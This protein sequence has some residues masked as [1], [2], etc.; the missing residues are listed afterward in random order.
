M[1][2]NG[3]GHNVKPLVAVTGK[4]T[5]LRALTFL[6]IGQA[7]IIVCAALFGGVS[8]QTAIFIGI[9]INGLIAAAALAIR[10]NAAFAVGDGSP[11]D[12]E[13]EQMARHAA[14]LDAFP[15]PILLL[16]GENRVELANSAT[17]EMFGELE[18]GAP[19]TSVVRAPSALEVLR[20]ARHS[21][22]PQEEEFTISA[23]SAMTALFYAAP[24]QITERAEKGEMI[25]M[26]RDRT[27]Q[28]MLERMRTDFLAN[29]GHE[30]RTPLA[31]LLGFIET[32]Q[33]HARDDAEA[34]AKFLKIM[35]SQTE[36]MLR[37]VQDL[38]SLS[39]LELNER[40]VP[41]ETVDL[42]EMAQ[43]TRDM[44]APVVERGNG[45][46]VPGP[47]N[48]QAEIM[49]ERDQLIQ[50][51]QNLVENSLR[52]GGRPNQRTRIH[53]SVGFGVDPAFK[54]ADKAGDNPEQVAVRADC[55]P[56]DLR[57]L[58]VRD[59]GFGIDAN[60]LPRI[61]ERF[62]RTDVQKSHA[63]P[64]TGLGLAIVKHIVGR[65][66]GGIVIESSPSE[67]AA[68]TCYFPPSQAAQLDI[69]ADST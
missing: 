14:F 2:L 50:V 35:E 31:S 38:V 25:V 7:A 18:E 6:T 17:R 69:A 27:E 64:G 45:E 16:D 60:D 53:V 59:E 19:I 34:R 66:R 4:R 30:L 12:Q 55:Q 37:L 47:T 46:M 32:L 28:K 63:V 33:G 44:M 67:G 13:A 56:Q 57:F 48:C 52:Y 29:A 10:S 1:E 61:T 65:H 11:L 20:T 51:I 23:P 22:A 39:T 62:Y 3:T 41:E 24:V 5:A 68:F 21:G 58:R 36:R 49:G 54:S 42:C 26:V 15:Q 40:R 9:S 43:A 8:W